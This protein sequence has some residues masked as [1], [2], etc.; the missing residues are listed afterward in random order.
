MFQMQLLWLLKTLKDS[1]SEIA[2][3]RLRFMTKTTDGFEIAEK[4]LE[5]RGSGEILGVRQHGLPEFKILDILRDCD[6]V[7]DSKDAIDF[8]YKNDSIKNEAYQKMSVYLNNKFEKMI[9]N[10][11]LN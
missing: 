7:K 8:L 10:L 11:A 4:D 6:I 2:L 9:G 1:K 3:E 5:L